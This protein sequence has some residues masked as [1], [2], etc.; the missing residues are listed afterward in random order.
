MDEFATMKDA[1][2]N[3][4]PNIGAAIFIGLGGTGLEVL[5]R[6][7]RM[8]DSDQKE[9][10][11]PFKFLLIDTD[12]RVKPR[13][14]KGIQ[15]VYAGEFSP[16]EF[17]EYHD[18][19][20]KS[21]FW[22]ENKR[23]WI[24]TLPRVKDGADQIRLIGRLAFY[25]RI[26]QIRTILES[27]VKDL[28]DLL[29]VLKSKGS[30]GATAT[31]DTFIIGSL[32]GGTGSS[33]FNDVAAAVHYVLKEKGYFDPQVT[34]IFLTADAFLQRIN[35]EFLKNR[36]KANTFAALAEYFYDK[37]ASLQNGALKPRLNPLADGESVT[38]DGKNFT[39]FI[40]IQ[41]TNEQ[42]RTA[43]TDDLYEFV[44]SSLYAMASIYGRV[45]ST[46]VNIQGVGAISKNLHM[47]D[48]LSSMGA[49]SIYY[50]KD[51]VLDYAVNVVLSKVIP[52]YFYNNN[53]NA[54]E[55]E[56]KK[57]G[58]EVEN[59]LDSLE[60][61]YST[62]KGK[63]S[64]HRQTS[65]LIE[66][67]V[68]NIKKDNVFNNPVNL[69]NIFKDPNLKTADEKLE[70]I[71]RIEDDKID[72]YKEQLGTLFEGSTDQL[73]NRQPS[74]V[75]KK[76]DAIKKELKDIYKNKDFGY[77][78]SFVFV[79]KNKL[80]AIEDV[81]NH[82]KAQDYTSM[83]SE[84]SGPKAVESAI[85]IYNGKI[86]ANKRKL[87]YLQ[88]Q[89][90]GILDEYYRRKASSLTFEYAAKLIEK[91]YEEVDKEF[92]MLRTFEATMKEM[93]ENIIKP[94]ID[95]FIRRFDETQ[96]VTPSKQS[97][98][99][100]REIEVL[101]DK[102]LQA[103]L[104]G[105]LI[106]NASYQSISETLYEEFKKHYNTW[107]KESYDESK[108]VSELKKWAKKVVLDTVKEHYSEVLSKLLDFSIYDALRELYDE[109]TTKEILERR[110]N[111]F[112]DVPPFVRV[113][114]SRIRQKNISVRNFLFLPADTNNDSKVDPYWKNI[115]NDVLGT[116]DGSGKI[117]YLPSPNKQLITF[118]RL[119]GGIGPAS[120]VTWTNYDSSYRKVISY[121]GDG[122][123][124][125][126]NVVPAL[127][128]KLVEK[129]LE[130]VVSLMKGGKIK[131]AAKK[132]SLLENIAI[133]YVLGNVI[134]KPDL[135]CS[136]KMLRK[137]D[138]DYWDKYVKELPDQG[139]GIKYYEF[140]PPNDYNKN[141]YTLF[142]YLKSLSSNSK[143]IDELSS[144]NQAV[145]KGM[146]KEEV[147]NKIKETIKGL[148]RNISASAMGGGIP[149]LIE[150]YKKIKSTLEDIIDYDY[151]I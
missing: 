15:F 65:S 60:L 52:A 13:V 5:S 98:L 54:H 76:V 3:D 42:G 141:L 71:K 119:R 38:I 86:F 75:D 136:I 9:G 68:K 137:L 23:P 131:S 138:D 33:M 19:E 123:E 108:S 73:G 26:Y 69:E 29:N 77:L 74:I 103:M 120:L 145:I 4:Q 129:K 113:D 41:D 62:E 96:R 142:N 61:N 45:V 2:T 10:G 39:N 89:G 132:D 106:D 46:G 35:E 82:K 59:L 127:A 104:K 37:G 64:G 100:A 133:G 80:K 146:H 84:N 124:R 55:A 130:D 22:R 24:G 83:Q 135:T 148:D 58:L 32:A 111:K 40:V 44:A 14:P 30:N 112:K 91:I 110:I 51:I 28:T 57:V 99:N 50:P 6:M 20:V 94:Q 88:K 87:A 1:K 11:K 90:L 70:R 115:A 53:N 21:W 18:E 143:V 85:S 117:D 27:Y 122:Y 47:P 34:G 128:D 102:E 149:E 79:L 121:E 116:M 66:G 49:Y 48:V 36:V 105:R 147:A 78:D 81:L 140:I 134:E 125:D 118:I 43:A 16:Q 144:I 67:L 114:P 7:K 25:T 12:E 63:H 17:V 95:G 126:E 107:N 31:I 56:E 8:M 72:K 150:L 109:D 151:T 139:D 93:Y 92:Q 101:V 97:I